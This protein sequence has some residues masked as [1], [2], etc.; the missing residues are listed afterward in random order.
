MSEKYVIETVAKRIIAEIV[1]SPD[2]GAELRKW[3]E[4]F[5]VTQAQLAKQMGI[6]QS[7]IVD[8]ERGKRKPGTEFLKKVVNALI[9]IDVSRGSPIIKML[10]MGISRLAPYI[11]DMADFAVPVNLYDVIPK[12]GYTLSVNL[13]NVKLYGYLVTDSIKAILAIEGIEFYQLL[14]NS[15]GRL[16][17]FTG[18]SSGRSPILALRLSSSITPLKPAAVALHRPK[19][20]DQL[21]LVLA[22]KS[23]IPII[24]STKKSVEELLD[25]LKSLPVQLG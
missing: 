24:V 17:V 3:R 15:V 2:P 5:K 18:V 4:T 9:E 1:W 20:P 16:W 7:V 19:S 13:P 8:Y 10:S 23:K 25:T 22:E 11:L 14:S 12:L 6:K 21:A